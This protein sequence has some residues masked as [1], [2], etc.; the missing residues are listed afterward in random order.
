MINTKKPHTYSQTILNHISL[1]LGQNLEIPAW[2]YYY[3]PSFYDDLL[4]L[5]DLKSDVDKNILFSESRK[6]LLQESIFVSYRLRKF[7]KI[8]F[9]D[10]YEAGLTTSLKFTVPFLEEGRLNKYI[11][12]S[13][14]ESGNQKGLSAFKSFIFSKGFQSESSSFLANFNLQNHLADVVSLAPT[15]KDTVN[16]FFLGESVLGNHLRPQAMLKNIYNSMLSGDFLIIS[17]DIYRD[18][19]EDLW[20]A[21]Y[22]NCLAESFSIS[23]ELAN[24]LSQGYPLKAVWEDKQGFRGVKIKTQ[25]QKPVSFAGV[26]LKEGQIVDL[27]RSTR[28]L[29]AEIISMLTKLNFKMI[30]VVYGN[31]MNTAMFV[32]QKCP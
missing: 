29:E 6:L 14:S 16:L 18:S 31:D 5:D 27:F 21:D 11:M 32:V 20:V 9:F 10:L 25:I 22:L 30:E 8:N 7:S 19:R 15:D 24:T 1:D 23:K 13:S 4:L 12:A 2:I 3:H 28:F 26:D 17:Q